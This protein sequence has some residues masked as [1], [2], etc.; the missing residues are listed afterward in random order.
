MIEIG[1]HALA[2]MAEA[3][4]QHGEAA[5]GHVDDLA[6]KLA[7]VCQHIAAEQVDFHPLETPAFLSG[8]SDL[9]SLH[10]RHFYFGRPDLR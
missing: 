3:G 1:D 4:R 10:Q 8:C 6:R 2:D 5:G 7:P 9:L